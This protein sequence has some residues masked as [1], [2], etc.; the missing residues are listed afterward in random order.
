MNFLTLVLPFLEKIIP[1][2]KA[3]AAAQAEALRLQQAG[4]M[5]ELDASVKL[6]VGQMDVNKAE[7]ASTSLFVSGW[8]PLV[9][10]VCAAGLAYQFVLHPLLC[11]FA[12]WK[13]VPVPPRLDMD[14]LLTI[15]TG[16][17]GLAGMRTSEKFKGVA[18]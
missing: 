11:W 13:G 12:A 1:D 3:R 9:G 4:Q 16:M 14:T 10:Y 6:A 7:A 17:L 8:R 2:P 5:A 15:L 18:R